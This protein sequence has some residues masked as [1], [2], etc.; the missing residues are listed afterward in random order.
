[1]IHIHAH[2]EFF[3][4]GIYDCWLHSGDLGKMNSDEYVYIVDRE[5]DMILTPKYSIY[6]AKIDRVLPNDPD[7]ALATCAEETDELKWEI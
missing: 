3:V 7:E 6:P 4:N 2:S 5:K 1:M